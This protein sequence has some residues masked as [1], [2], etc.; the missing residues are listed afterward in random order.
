MLAMRH[1]RGPGACGGIAWWQEP[2]TAVE[3]DPVRAGDI[4][5]PSGRAAE[6]GEPI[7]CGTCGRPMQL[8][9]SVEDY[10]QS[11]VIGRMRKRG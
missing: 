1:T 10:A 7:A 8:P 2:H 9:I 6:A 11:R 4:V 3:G 5:F